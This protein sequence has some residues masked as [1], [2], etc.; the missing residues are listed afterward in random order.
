MQLPVDVK[1]LFDEMTNIGAARDTELSVSVYVDNAAAAD[2]VAHIRSAF[3][4]TSSMVRMT[5][6]YLDR[7][8][9]PN[10][11]DDI[12]LL[13]AGRS[14]SVGAAAA[15][16]RGMDVPV[17]VITTHP[18]TADRLARE[19]GYAIPEGDLIAPID[20]GDSLEKDEPIPLTDELAKVL[21]E[22]LGSWIAA[23]CREKRLAFALAF[24][25]LRRPL[26]VDAV[27]ATSLQNAGIGLVPFIP[28]ADLPVMTLN[29]AK[30]V[31]QIAAA[32]GQ[33]M[34]KERAKELLAVVGG[35][36]L[37]RTVARELIEFVPVIGFVV[38]TGVA[39][40]GTAAIGHAV[41]D[42]YEGG[43]NAAGVAN[44]ATQAIKTANEV[45]TMVRD[46]P[47]EIVARVRVQL[48]RCVPVMHDAVDV[49]VPVV[50]DMVVEYAPKAR[51]MMSEY[52]PL[53]KQT[54]GDLA[55]SGVTKG[56]SEPSADQR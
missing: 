18:A 19:A 7:S 30:M 12:A 5:L 51:T 35:A 50:R 34:N 24:S 37:W 46:N 42:Y 26:A 21:D 8:F 27:K 10:T 15:A 39:Y 55:R 9:F 40:G 45:A 52:G 3:A 44:I 56:A 41:I 1:A 25:F 31:L 53:L 28:G 16:I 2:V 33:D 13:I 32:Y 22:R 47:G 38:R 20:L 29:Q 4:S 36:Y 23:K 43:Q 54:I 6:M 11:D 48:G 17:A 14:R 49:Y